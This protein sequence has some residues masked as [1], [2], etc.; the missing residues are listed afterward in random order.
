M[1]V[2]GDAWTYLT[3]GASWTGNGGM[4]ELL[5]Q[6]LLLSIT[7]LVLAVVVALP[8]AFWLG[9]IGKGGFLAVSI[10]NIGRA[11]PTLAL[12]AILVRAE[13]PGTA[14]LGP[15]G[16][17][18]LA[19]LIALALFALP[20]LITQTYV[21]VREVPADTKEAAVG[22]GMTGW[23]L[24]LRVELPLALPLVLSGVRLAIV[25]VWATAT[26]AAL[27]AGPGLGNVITAG[28]A[29]QRY[30]Q[31]I[32]GAI[33]VAAVALALE[34]AAALAVRAITRERAA[35]PGSTPRNSAAPHPAG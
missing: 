28:F 16:R 27:V 30:G 35:D 14:H 3:D 34:V 20:P 32:A 23:Q 10:S 7:A 24:F 22:L 21:A 17:A 29:N 15:Y 12:L 19:T 4:L 8:I 13:W 9:H 25:Q 33:V 2:F 1:D 26:I 6:Q 11:V 31:G 5:V 18:G